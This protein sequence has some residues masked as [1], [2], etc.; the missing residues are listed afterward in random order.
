MKRRSPKAVGSRPVYMDID[1]L[2][3]ENQK[4]NPRPL[5]TGEMIRALTHGE[6]RVEIRKLAK[7]YATK[8]G[9]SEEEFIVEANRR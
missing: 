3:K 6:S 2:L 1:S 4:R 5:S 7:R 8:L 9:V